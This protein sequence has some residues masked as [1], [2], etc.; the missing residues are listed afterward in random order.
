MWRLGFRTVLA[1]AVVVATAFPAHARALSVDDLLARALA[2][3]RFALAPG[4][5]IPYELTA[6]FSATLLLR[7]HGAR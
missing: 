5:K 2:P 4:H 3:Q 1:G 6:D 7:V